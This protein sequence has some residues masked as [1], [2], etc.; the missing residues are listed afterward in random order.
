VAISVKA[1]IDLLLE[2]KAL[3]KEIGTKGGYTSYTTRNGKTRL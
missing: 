2:R 1:K 3:P